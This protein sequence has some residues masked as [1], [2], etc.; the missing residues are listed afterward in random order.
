MLQEPEG[1]NAKKVS[2]THKEVEKKKQKSPKK[3][4]LIIRIPKEKFNKHLKTKTKLNHDYENEIKRKIKSLE[5]V[6]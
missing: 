3:G 6:A 1:E 4:W 5:K 2:L